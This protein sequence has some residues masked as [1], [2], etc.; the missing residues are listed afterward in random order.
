MNAQERAVMQHAL[1]AIESDNQGDLRKAMVNIATL[2][3]APALL[4]ATKDAALESM[5]VMQLALEA[6]TEVYYTDATTPPKQKT[7]IEAMRQTLAVPAK[8]MHPDD[9]AVDDFAAAMKAKMAKQRAKGYDGWDDK[10]ACPSERLQRMLAEHVRKGDP[11]DVANFAMML[12]T[13]QES[14]AQPMTEPVAFVGA[15]GVLY[16]EGTEPVEEISRRHS[17]KVGDK[18]YAAPQPPAQP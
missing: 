7:A 12:W 17:L 11:V 1:A 5:A 2:L 15:T 14:T 9:I 6:L 8:P 18:L 3:E 4:L 16:W 13:R 10:T